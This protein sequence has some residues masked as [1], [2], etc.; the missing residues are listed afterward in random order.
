M[1][2]L[3]IR[4]RLWFKLWFT[5]VHSIVLMLLIPLIVYFIYTIQSY[6]IAYLSSMIYEKAATLIYVFILQWC[7]SLD[8]DSKFYGQLITYPI[9]RWKLVVERLLLASLIFISFMCIVTMLLTPLI[10][11][12]IWKGLL[13]S[14]PVYIGLA[15]IVILAVII[16]NHSLGGLFAGLVFWMISLNGDALLYLNPALLQFSGVYESLSGTSGLFA[17]DAHWILYNRLFYMS[18]GVLFSVLA[19]WHFNRKSV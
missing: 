16:G 12:F 19:V 1:S 6:K 8:F 14:I 11:S 7:F 18:L 13:F 2:G 9:S 10:G 15:G 5:S 3:S 4:L 17:N